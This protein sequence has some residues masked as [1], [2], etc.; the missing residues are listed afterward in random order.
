MSIVKTE[1]DKNYFE[2]YFYKEIPNSQRNRN[3]LKELM[4]HKEKGKLLEIGC[5][6]GHFLREAR[7]FFE[8]D[9]IEFSEYA[10]NKARKYL[11]ENVLEGDIENIQLERH[12]YDAIVVFNILEHL[13][14]PMKTIEKLYDSLQDEGILIGSVPNN[15]G[16]IG[17]LATQISNII[18]K[19][20]L[21][22]YPTEIWWNHF[23]KA[24]FSQ[25]FFS[26]KYP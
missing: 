23:K 6:E 11:G 3:R 22:T 1:Y 15:F 10:V 24:G 8:V 26:V 13:K 21:S 20:H 12:F 17:G 25:V 19:T 5:A 7:T 18:D 14:D 16:I 2:N 9:G 4:I